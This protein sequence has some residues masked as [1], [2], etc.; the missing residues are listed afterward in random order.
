MPAKRRRTSE[1]AA[2]ESLSSV[3]SESEASDSSEPDLAENIKFQDMEVFICPGEHRHGILGYLKRFWGNY[4]FFLA[5]TKHTFQNKKAVQLLV[6]EETGS[7]RHGTN[8]D[9][10]HGM[11]RIISIHTPGR[12]YPAFQ[13]DD[14]RFVGK[15]EMVRVKHLHYNYKVRDPQALQSL[16]GG[17]S[18]AVPSPFRTSPHYNYWNAWHAYTELPQSRR[19]CLMRVPGVCHCRHCV[20]YEAAF[21][22]PG[23]YGTKYL[24]ECNECKKW[25]RCLPS[26]PP[27]FGRVPNALQ[28]CRCLVHCTFSSGANCDAR[29][30]CSNACFWRFNG[31]NNPYGSVQY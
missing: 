23:A 21:T 13:L 9:Y 30:F 28:P 29:F 2:V 16:V 22:G 6:L 20:Q 11:W 25:F 8:T 17:L 4:P 26:V 15:V 27:Q 10:I 1:A 7:D 24:H 14:A 5:R 19:R 3:E 12:T 18:N 31:D